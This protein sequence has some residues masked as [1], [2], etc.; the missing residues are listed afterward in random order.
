MNEWAI[1]DTARIGDFC[2]NSALVINTLISAVRNKTGIISKW[3][4]LPDPINGFPN[5]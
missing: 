4:P 3:K 5:V 2:N 1:N